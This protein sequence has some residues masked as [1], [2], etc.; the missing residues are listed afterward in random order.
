MS[1]NDRD[2]KT[3]E[4]YGIL[5]QL[6]Q[7]REAILE[8]D[9]ADDVTFD[10]KYFQL[11]NPY[12]AVAL[13]HHTP[14]EHYLRVR[15][16]MLRR[17]YEAADNCGFQKLQADLFDLDRCCYFS[18][19]PKTETEVKPKMHIE[20][21]PLQERIDLLNDSCC[22]HQEYI[23][24]EIYRFADLPITTYFDGMEDKLTSLEQLFDIPHDTM[25]DM[26]YMQLVST[27]HDT[28]YC[29]EECLHEAMELLAAP[30]A[31]LYNGQPEHDGK[32]N[33]PQGVKKSQRMSLEKRLENRV[34]LENCI[35]LNMDVKDFLL[36]M[37]EMVSTGGTR[38]ESVY[39]RYF[40]EYRDQT[41]VPLIAESGKMTAEQRNDIRYNLLIRPFARLDQSHRTKY[42]P[43]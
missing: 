41:F 4:Q 30:L 10:L 11:D 19:K 7:L 29:G 23:A 12:V 28:P 8:V 17:V 18:L 26:T 42:A 3:A 43:K 27:I 24:A 5:H 33:A 22:A 39:A 14:E 40:Q 2:R 9:G 32:D 15:G 21:I 34:T 35:M 13:K 36:F 37:D 1:L 20:K 6:E 25:Q 16:K 31:R 38:F